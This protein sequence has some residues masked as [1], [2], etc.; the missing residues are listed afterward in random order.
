MI[1]RYMGLIVVPGAHVVKVEVE[2][3]GAWDLDEDEDEDEN[4]ESSNPAHASLELEGPG[5]QAGLQE[6]LREVAEEA[7]GAG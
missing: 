7:S 2:G 4:E 3:A 5:E 6:V 1:P